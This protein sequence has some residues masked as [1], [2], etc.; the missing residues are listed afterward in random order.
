M[1]ISRFLLM[2]K[3]ATSQFRITVVLQNGQQAILPITS[4][5][6]FNATVAVLNRGNAIMTPDGTIEA[7]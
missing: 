4:I 2:F 7:Q 6:A 5:D 3:P 1:P